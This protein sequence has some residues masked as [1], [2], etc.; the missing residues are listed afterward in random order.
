M[1]KKVGIFFGPTGGKTE[2]IA[3]K[4]QQA[5][6][7]N[8]ADLIPVKDS[9]A[10]DLDR[11]DNIVLGCSTIGKETW[12]AER[13]KD[14]WDLFR[15]EIDKINYEGKSFA[16]FGLG[17]SVTYA[18]TFV[19]AMGVL[20]KIMLT[21]DAKIVGQVPTS[22]YNFTDSEAVI[23]NQFVGLPI[24]EDFEKDKTDKRIS[25]WVEELKKK[26]V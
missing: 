15:P 13:T 4:V 2:N 5:F 12:N 6:G 21:N 18:A 23:D 26:F 1:K 22:K 10:S 25:E 9:K 7:P 8:M 3:K 20:A 19:D 24:D 14:D 16:L 17:D 11:Y